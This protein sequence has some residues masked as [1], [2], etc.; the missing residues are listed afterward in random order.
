MY[1]LRLPLCNGV[2]DIT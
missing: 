2:L 1:V